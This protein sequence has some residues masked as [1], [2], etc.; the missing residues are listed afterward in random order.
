MILEL[1]TIILLKSVIKLL[2]L[3][4][5]L[6]IVNLKSRAFLILL[7]IWIRMLKIFSLLNIV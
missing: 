4:I 5:R 2:N 3:I 7:K 1:L 6:D